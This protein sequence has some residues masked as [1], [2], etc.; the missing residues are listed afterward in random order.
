MGQCSGKVAVSPSTLAPV[1]P[2]A[3][4]SKS[5][6][7][8]DA[9]RRR[10]LT[11]GK[12]FFIE[13]SR[14]LSNCNSVVRVSKSSNIIDKLKESVKNLPS[15]E[16]ITPEQRDA[17]LNSMGIEEYKAGDIVCEK[18]ERGTYFSIVCH[19]E[20]EILQ[21]KDNGDDNSE[22]NEN[23]TLSS[24]EDSILKIPK[25]LKAWDHFGEMALVFEGDNQ[26]TIKAITDGSVYVL[27]RLTYQRVLV[28]TATDISSANTSFLSQVPILAPLTVEQR[29]KLADCLVPKKYEKDTF[30]VHQGERGDTF[31]L[32]E[33]GEVAVVER[34]MK[35]GKQVEE[36][37]KRRGRGWY[38]GEG[39]LQSEEGVRNADVKAVS[40]CT[41]LTLGRREFHDLLGPLHDLINRNFKKR[42]LMTLDLLKKLN[43]EQLDGVVDQMVTR[44]YEDGEYICKQGEA[45][46]TFFIIE[47]GQV[48]VTRKEEALDPE[49]SIKSQ[50]RALSPREDEET[51]IGTLIHGEYFG[52]GALLTNAPRRA[53]IIATNKVTCITLSREAFENALGP[54][55]KMLDE[56]FNA[57]KGSTSA[58]N[59]QWSDIQKIRA[60]GSGSY[61][62]VTIVRHKITG[63]TYALKQIRKAT[64]I[65]KKQEKFIRN[66]RNILSKLNH[67]FIVNLVRTFKDEESVY[68]LME[69]CLGGELYA[70]MKATVDKIMVTS[71]DE[72]PGCFPMKTCK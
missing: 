32:V 5:V 21:D 68:M 41:C 53:N 31:F 36:E 22:E 14:I 65:M 2:V 23:S 33:S 11:K 62:T 44:V 63:Q 19:G 43:D 51:E 57:R 24:D 38:F 58:S 28:K 71:K 42:V 50:R 67:P 13:D 70:H 37:L 30:I 27:D 3:E 20:F 18:N 4:P 12:K 29:E 52:E 55:R 46:D 26:R 1:T 59:V 48:R 45:G 66:E 72:V 64:V 6:R 34:K 25:K 17:V 10:S 40:T 69:I 49:S 54:L 39:A 16:N 47:E 8:K 60:I 35:D 9:L 61:G 15:F 56:N 7:E